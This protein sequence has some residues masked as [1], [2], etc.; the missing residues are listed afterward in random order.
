MKRCAFCGGKGAVAPNRT[1]A[2]LRYTAYCTAS[3]Y[4]PCIVR[5]TAARAELAWDTR[6]DKPG[7]WYML[8]DFGRW[9]RKKWAGYQYD[10]WLRKD[11]DDSDR[12]SW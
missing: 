8:R 9:L 12:G 2:G 5:E 4:C 3:S 1:Q 11:A 10:R 6:A 7:I